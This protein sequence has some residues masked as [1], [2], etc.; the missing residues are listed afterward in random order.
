MSALEGGSIAPPGW[1]DSEEAITSTPAVLSRLPI[2]QPPAEAAVRWRIGAAVVDNLIVYGLYLLVCLV[3]HWRVADVGHLLVL[4]LLGV[5]YHFALESRDGQTI[6]KRRYGIR[7]VSLDGTPASPKAIA[8]RSLLRVIDS[9]PLWYFSGLL[10][11]VRTGPQRRQRIGD[12]VGETKVVAVQGR[13]AASGTPKWYLPAATLA[14]LAVSLVAV[15]GIAEAGH[16]PLTS[17]EQAQFVAGCENTGGAVIDCQCLL[18]RLESDGY[19]TPDSLRAVFSQAEA[20][21]INGESGT[22]RNELTTDAIA[23][24]R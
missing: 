9:L 22:A 21:R 10:S 20:E 18:N 12:V 2:A 17:T 4:V 15:V 19:T 23:C 13:A 3:L 7:V 16:Q 14:A 8:V 24:H 11:M 5:V 1:G 6:G